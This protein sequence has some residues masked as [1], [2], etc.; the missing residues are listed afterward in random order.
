[1]AQHVLNFVRTT[2]RA[3]LGLSDTQLLLASGTGSQFNAIA[4][5]DWCYITV[6]DA[7][8]AEVVKYTSGGDVVNDTL[9]V[10]R[11]QDGTG[12]KAFPVGACVAVGWN[13]AQVTAL[14]Q[15]VAAFPTITTQ[16]VTTPAAPPPEGVIFAIN[17]STGDV[18]FWTGAVWVYLNSNSTQLMTVA[19]TDPPPHNVTWAINTITLSLYY[20]TGLTWILVSGGGGIGYREILGRQYLTLGSGIPVTVGSEQTFSAMVTAG[21][22]VLPSVS[23]KSDPTIAGVIQIESNNL[24]KFL[25]PCIVQLTAT[26]QGDM[27]DFTHD[28]SAGLSIFHAADSYEWLTRQCIPANSGWTVVGMNVSTGP[29]EVTANDEWDVNLVI[30]NGGGT[31]VGFSVKQYTFTASVIALL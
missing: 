22:G 9:I 29:V 23:Y 27:D 20:W 4:A 28:F 25:A 30:N 26:V 18:W 17:N 5:G 16:V 7:V 19:P 12:A 10:E 3:P 14:V 31:Y 8:N 21:M 1:M 2:L 11:A 13:V 24:L 15:Q 6:N